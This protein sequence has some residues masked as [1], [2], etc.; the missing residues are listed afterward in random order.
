MKPRKELLI[1]AA[2]IVFALTGCATK[3]A[4][5]EPG[6][7]QVV[8]GFSQ[9][10]IS[11]CIRSVVDSIVSQDR[12]KPLPGANRAVVVVKNVVNDT[13]SRGRDAG[14][15]AEALGLS[16]R[17]ELT[18][19]GKIVVFNE[20]AAQYA[21]VKVEPQYALFGRLTQ[22]TLRQDNGDIQIEYNLNLQLVDL[23]TGL[24]FW[25]KRVP[26]RKLA[27]QRNVM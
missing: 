12:I 2:A 4:Y 13:L 26:I 21:K 1:Y 14:A 10:D 15:L 25:Q 16:L 17:E 20:T 24:E 9:D 27:D 5:I 7:A 6:T 11:M 3:T 8:A 22:R 19:C 23:S 18:N